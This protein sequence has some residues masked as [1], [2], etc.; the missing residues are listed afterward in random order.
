[1]DAEER[2]GIRR[3]NYMDQKQR[4]SKEGKPKS[5]SLAPGVVIIDVDSDD[6][7]K[8]EQSIHAFS[9]SSLRVAS[10]ACGRCTFINDGDRNSCAMCNH[11]NVNSCANEDAAATN[12]DQR[13]EGDGKSDDDDQSVT[14]VPNPSMTHQRSKRTR[15]DNFSCYM[16]GNE[17][18]DTHPKAT[19]S[20]GWVWAKTHQFVNLLEEIE[21]DAQGLVDAFKSMVRTRSPKEITRDIVLGLAEEHGVTC[22]KWLIYQ[23]ADHAAQIWQKIRDAL[24]D[25]RLGSV[26]KIGKRPF[27]NGN[28]V[29]CV[30]CDDF[31]DKQDNNAE[32]TLY[33]VR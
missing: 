20:G 1:M 27:E 21:E 28:F 6:S 30:Y 23:K 29:I 19:E 24:Y 14:F 10:W 11:D 12:V 18:C 9:S 31:R 5:A 13:D 16:I 15:A 22:G 7:E 17:L 8:N 2:R 32:V 3:E 33:D 4:E 26:A 25:N